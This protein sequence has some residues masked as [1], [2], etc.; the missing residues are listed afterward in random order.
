MKSFKQ[1][2]T[3][4]AVVV[5]GAFAAQGAMAA[6]C[7]APEAPAAMPDGKT[8]Q[9]DAMLAAKRSV[10][11]YVQKV[12]DYMKCEGDARKLQEAKARRTEIL[13]WFNAEVRAFNEASSPVKNASYR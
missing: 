6:S 13:K 1:V 4:L 12:V 2:H 7:S 5:L 11:A 10:D 9:M 3:V 8:A